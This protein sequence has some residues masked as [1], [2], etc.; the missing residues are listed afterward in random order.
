MKTMKRFSAILIAVLMMVA[1]MVAP[2]SAANPTYTITI[3][4][5]DT[6]HQYEAYQIFAG[7]LYTTGGTGGVPE[8]IVL[9]DIVWGTGVNTAGQTALGNAASVASSLSSTAVA[10]AFAETLVSSGYLGAVAGTSTYA[11]GQY[12]ISDLPAGYYLVKDV[13]GSIGNDAFHAYTDYI[14]KVVKDVTVDPKA[15]TP[16]LTKT[17]SN[18]V[19]GN[20]GE[21]ISTAIG[22]TF[23]FELNGSLPSMISSYG[24]YTMTFVDTLPAGMVYENNV[25]VLVTNDN[26][27]T[28]YTV[29]TDKYTVNYDS[30]SG[31]L[32]VSVTDAV[33]T[34]NALTGNVPL[35]DDNIVVKFA[36]SLN[37]DA[38]IG[39]AGNENTAVLQ[40]SND[41][42][43][44]S[45]Y[46]TTSEQSAEV[47]TYAMQLVKVD[48]NN[49]ATKLPNAKFILWRYEGSSTTDIRYA[50]ANDEGNGMYTITGV[51]ADKALATEFVTDANGQFTVNGI[52]DGTYHMTETAPPAGYNSLDSDFGFNVTA[53]LNA[54]SGDVTAFSAVK[55][56]TLAVVSVSADAD[57]C[58]A[59]VTVQNTAGSQLPETG[60]I[61]T[62]VFYGIGALLVIGALALLTVRKRSSAK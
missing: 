41:P 44:A 10:H 37:E 17:V 49:A 25:Q 58:T 42:N 12:T 21:A 53:T 3:T 39:K 34:I 46:G 55:A 7:D 9:S 47:Y 8:S 14:L 62:T 33:S 20:Y 27:A 6:G 5:T 4:G 54:A 28:T 16:T 2:A 13:S 18:T 1:M 19:D 57:N 32:T 59:I 61:G 24:T 60:G 23:Y 51:T 43:N 40:F 26:N 22:R 48:G 31:K 36:A 38:V 52:A 50:V 29:P 15:A 45:S 11:G 35:V 30:A 56:G